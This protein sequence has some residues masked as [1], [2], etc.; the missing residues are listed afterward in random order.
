MSG[1][2]TMTM[3]V[4]TDQMSLLTVRTPHVW[5]ATSCAPALGAVYQKPG[6][7]MVTM[8]AARQ[9]PVMSLVNVV[10]GVP[11]SQTTVIS[12]TL[13]SFLHPAVGPVLL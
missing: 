6:N 3:T 1:A 13:S 2:V 8:T 11:L 12:L 4:A 7:V 10:S 5:Q 9:I